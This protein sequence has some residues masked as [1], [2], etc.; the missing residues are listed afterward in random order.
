[1]RTDNFNS[2]LL[3]TLMI[4]ALMAPAITMILLLSVSPASAAPSYENI[5]K[6]GEN[7]YN[8]DINPPPPWIGYGPDKIKH[9][10]IMAAKVVG[11][12]KVVAAGLCHACRDGRWNDASIP[13]NYRHLDN[14]LHY[15]FQWMGGTNV[16]WYENYEVYNDTTMCAQLVT[17]LRDKGYTITGETRRPIRKSWL[18]TYDI[19]V[20]PQLELGK[21]E[22]GGDPKQLPDADVAAIADWVENSGGGLL[23]MDGAD[24]FTYNFCKV[25]NKVLKGL[26]FGIYFQ[27]DELRDPTYNWGAEWEMYAD[28]DNTT[29]IGS[30]YENE[31]GTK[32][33][34]V[35]MPCSLAEKGDYELGLS[36]SPG[37][38]VF[39]EGFPGGTLKYDVEVT[40][41][42]WKADNFDLTVVENTWPAVLSDTLLE[43]VQRENSK[44]T[45]LTVTIPPDASFGDEDTITV[46]AT[47][48]GNSAK[49]KKENCRAVAAMRIGPPK[50][51]A[52]VSSAEPDKYFGGHIWMWVISSENTYKVGTDIYKNMRTWMRLDLRGIPDV[53]PPGSWTT[54]NLRARLYAYCW[55]IHGAWGNNVECWSSDNDNWEEREMAITWNNQPALKDKLDTT[56]I[57]Y[58]NGW[59][60]W[61]VTDFVRSE[62]AAGENFATFCLKAGTENLPYPEN[63]GVEFYPKERYEENIHLPHIAI[64][65][66][67]DA[68]ITPEYGEA[69]P[70]GMISYSVKVLN[71][72][73]FADN[74]TLENTDDAGWG[75]SIPSRVV[76]VQPNEVRRVDLDVKI[77]ESASPCAE[78]DNVLVTVKS[79]SYPENANDSDNCIAHPAENRILPAKEDSST[80]GEGLVP[81][82]NS[83]WGGKGK[84][85]IW[86]GRER[87]F[88]ARMLHPVAPERG[89][90]KFDLRGIPS[91]E[92][93]ASAKLNLYCYSP[94]DE[95]TLGAENGGAYVQ[96]YSVSDDSWSEDTMGWLNKPPIDNLIDTR[97]VSEE[98]KWYSWDVTDFV[99]D[100]YQG[101][102]VASFCLVD[103]GENLDPYNL[104]GHFAQFDSKE[105]GNENQ[106]PYLE[107]LSERPAREVRVY[108][109][110]VFHCGLPSTTLT[111]TV[112]VKNTGTEND[113]YALEN[114]DNLEWP[115]SLDNT[116]LFVPA[117]GT[118]Q[119]TLRVQIPS[120]S[121]GELDNITVT[122]TGSGVSDTIRCFAYRG[123]ALTVL[124]NLYKI[125]I[126]KNLILRDD[127]D[128]LV[129]KFLTYGGSLQ[130]NTSQWD[131]AWP[132]QLV[133]KEYIPH[134]GG[135][136]V[137][138]V[139]LVL[140]AKGSEIQ[141]IMSFPV[142]KSILFGRYLAI[143]M[144]YPKPWADKV[145]LFSEFL[146]IKSQYPKAPM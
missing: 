93:V 78:N 96:V 89:W 66:G 57:T 137:E 79:E 146:K 17:A 63:F 115:L 48:H 61:D 114:S 109:E 28:V 116:S 136:P 24:T 95:P 43:N 12:G 11:S 59:F 3:S 42:G 85:S 69:L 130:E 39:Q 121:V 110:P 111:Y 113:T 117:S 62:L 100:Q 51:D 141:T 125:S 82:E 26:E 68:E 120:G 75:L 142:T 8:R 22:P 18:N 128:N 138:K 54:D 16:A 112:T 4:V 104:I 119:T 105:S 98:D 47:S 60:S 9:P 19:L 10:P 23:I 56:R 118:G 108:I 38:P 77:P 46:K 86:V 73:S 127:A 37:V 36:V 5:A 70:G 33:V 20:L 58:D 143:K 71:R 103:L 35:Y 30:K 44:R 32:K 14:L 102:N 123:K 135:V 25:Q 31:E 29:W 6:L 34:G 133:D 107:V 67:V 97:E 21:E 83:V 90:L 49:F 99:R 80:R 87:T 50:A 15:T 144:E 84:D 145:A 52:Q 140:M 41:L 92:N 122:A 132:W 94:P 64:G 2:V 53:I 40:A 131:K 106:W 129:V 7:A 101:D 134:P 72:G 126:D 13:E 88:S 27:S 76:N 81:L 91:L 124:E 65:Y 55:G 74:Y 1:M 139:T 45:T